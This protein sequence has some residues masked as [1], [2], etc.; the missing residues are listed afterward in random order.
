MEEMVAVLSNDYSITQNGLF[1]SKEQ[2]TKKKERSMVNLVE[3]MR[4]AMLDISEQLTELSGEVKR[5]IQQISL[6]L[7]PFLNFKEKGV[8]CYTHTHTHTHTHTLNT[9]THSHT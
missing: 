1:V 2:P 7:K 9:L 6:L 5:Y 4:K 8:R 3:V